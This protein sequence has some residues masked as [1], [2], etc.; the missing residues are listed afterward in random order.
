MA[1]YAPVTSAEVV[2]GT[3]TVL[4][5]V[6][7]DTVLSDRALSRIEASVAENTRRAYR[8]DWTDFAGWCAEAGRFALPAT[9]QTLTEYISARCDLG[10]A[11]ASISRAISAIRVAHR[12][13]GHAPPDTLTARAVLKS[14]KNERA[15]SG[16]PNGKPSAVLPVDHLR[17][18]SAALAENG[19]AMGQRDRLVLVLGWAMMARRSELIGLDIEDISERDE[20][21]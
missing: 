21:L 10:R 18:I 20:G 7:A 11:P 2:T 16:L 14:Y 3:V 13:N 15:S 19:G 4:G 6:S 5:P 17:K 9:P 1:N 8:A 12:A